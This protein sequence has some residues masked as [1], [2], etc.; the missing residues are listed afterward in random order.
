MSGLV[1]F[2]HNCVWEQKKD[3]ICSISELPLHCPY[4]KYC[5]SP[6]IKEGNQDNLK[7]FK[8]RASTTCWQMAFSNVKMRLVLTKSLPF[9]QSKTSQNWNKVFRR[10]S[11]TCLMKKH[12][13]LSNIRT[14]YCLRVTFIL[15][16]VLF[17]SHICSWGKNWDV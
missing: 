2:K 14:F 17:S 11:R 13:Q 16:P 10:S 7:L 6:L 1:K 9:C 12:R 4:L 8:N 15:I 5:P 3:N